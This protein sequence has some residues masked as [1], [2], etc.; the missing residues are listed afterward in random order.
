[1]QVL[2]IIFFLVNFNQQAKSCGG[3]PLEINAYLGKGGTKEELTVILNPNDS[4]NRK[5]YKIVDDDGYAS[6]LF[7]L[8]LVSSNKNY[9]NL[10]PLLIKNLQKNITYNKRYIETELSEV[11]EDSTM[12]AKNKSD[13]EKYTKMLKTSEELLEKVKNEKLNQQHFGKLSSLLRTQFESEYYFKEYKNGK[14]D[15]LSIEPTPLRTIITNENFD[16][17]LGLLDSD[18]EKIDY[19][20]VCAGI[21]LNWAD[22]PDDSNI[23][24]T[25]SLSGSHPNK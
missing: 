24:V 25:N 22:T 7:M 15:N 1:M 9:D 17:L 12:N 18:G 23:N 20:G 21:N 4:K 2:L 14:Y 5:S 11:T 6:L 10:K 8:P 13:K 19:R 16:S 3:K